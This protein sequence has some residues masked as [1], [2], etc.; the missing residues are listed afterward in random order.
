MPWTNDRRFEEL[1]EF[2]HEDVR[3]NDTQQG[4]HRY[5]AGLRAVVEAFPDYHWDLRRLL[6][7]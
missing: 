3:V 4:L 5:V 2:I 7:E 1:G 6:D